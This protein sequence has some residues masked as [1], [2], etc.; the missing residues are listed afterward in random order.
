MKKEI[1]IILLF[2]FLLGFGNDG[3]GQKIRF[4]NWHDY[5]VYDTLNFE[6]AFIE[7]TQL[8]EDSRIIQ[9]FNR[10]SVKIKRTIELF[11][12]N[13]QILSRNRMEFFNSGKIRSVDV[14]NFEK[15]TRECKE[16]Y[17]NGNKK[18]HFIESNEKMTFE[19][20]F[21]EEG[22]QIPKPIF[23]N[24]GPEGGIEKWNEYLSKNLRYPLESQKLGIE[25][26][27][28]LYIIIEKDGTMVDL[29]LA[30][31]EEVDPE[32]AE[33]AIKVVKRY[34][35][36]WIPSSVNG[37]FMKTRIRLPINFRLTD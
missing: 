10:D 36:R 5:P 20:Y 6:Y 24:G 21:S 31:P 27:V 25:G 11:N 33:E 23:I 22:I 16:Y 28:I 17:E 32:L 15:G 19:Q 12:Q 4:L 8:S 3:F 30:N 1:K 18:S 29:A 34:S 35:G 26:L 13:N 9:V 37:E 2:G 14:Q 7:V